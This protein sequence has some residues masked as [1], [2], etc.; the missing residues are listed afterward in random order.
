MSP[1]ESTSTPISPREKARDLAEHALEPFRHLGRDTGLDRRLLLEGRHQAVG[2]QSQRGQ[3]LGRG[4]V[5]FLADALLFHG[6]HLE[7]LPLQG[8]AGAEVA[9]DAGE[10]AAGPGLRTR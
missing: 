2:Q 9:Q 1:S 7:H 4:V 3:L 5:Q 10:H 6:R 8:L